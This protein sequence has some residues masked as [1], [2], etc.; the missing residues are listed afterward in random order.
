MGKEMTPREQLSQLI[1]Q[2]YDTNM[3]PVDLQNLILAAVPLIVE[4]CR[5]ADYRGDYT[6][7]TVE[8]IITALKGTE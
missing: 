5:Q 7:N 1:E 4:L 8:S 2:H 6:F 3:H